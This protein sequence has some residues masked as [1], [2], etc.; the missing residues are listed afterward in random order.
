MVSQKA[1][2]ISIVVSPETSPS[3]LFG[4]FDVLSSVGIGWEKYVTGEPEMPQF[5]VKIVAASSD[6][7]ECSG[8]VLVTPHLGIDEVDQTDVVIV[9]S[10]LVPASIPLKDY[11]QNTLKW[12]R[13]QQSHG[14]IIASAC[15]G[16][17]VL[18]QAGM[19]DG[20]EATSHWAYRDLFR[21]HYP[22]VRLRLGQNLVG[23]GHN[24]KIVTSGGTTAWQELALHLITRYCGIEYTVRSVRFW[25]IPDREEN[26]GQYAAMPLGIPHNDALIER[27]QLWVADHY[28]DPNP[29]TTLIDQ[30]GLPPTTFSRRFKR[31]T[32]YNPMDYVH[33]TRM[34]HAKDLLTKEA[35]NIDE[36]GFLVGYE[37]P[38]SF[39]RLFKR[40]SGISPS[41]YRRRF[42][43]Y[44]FARYE[45]KS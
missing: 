44:R 16:A 24:N 26:Q 25:L 41:H 1:V 7:V 18:A 17:L 35:H 33:A 39:R 6:P 3:T 31:A 37:D 10:L 9:A 23:T 32:G 27:S 11:D 14:A 40:K 15:T 19:L 13:E 21:I 5:N 4:L 45:L 28:A 42:G 2:S 20:L 38:A 34:E 22:G 30:S 8:N 36:I 43:H 12:L 29:V